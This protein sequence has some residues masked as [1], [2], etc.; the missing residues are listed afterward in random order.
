MDTHSIKVTVITVTY[1]AK[2]ALEKTMHSID[3]Q[4]YTNLEY[5][6]VDGGSLDGT[7]SLLNSYTGKLER[8]ISEPDMG[9]YDAMNKGVAM[10]TGDYCLFMN[11]GD[12]FAGPSVV[13][14]VV[15]K[16]GGADVIYGDILKDGNLKK[17]LSPRNCHK[18]YYC[19]QAVFTR[20]N[21]LKEYPF[22][23]SHRFS[24]D[25]KQ[26]KQLY[27][28]GKTFKQTNIVI[29]VFDTTGISNTQRS[30]GL[31]DNIRVICEVDSIQEKIRILPRIL[32]SYWFCRL[33]GK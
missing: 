30:K 14:Q 28:A 6:V 2:D 31:L 5:I 10:A 11:A 9:I 20:T 32:F 27:L 21:C 12:C 16:F 26:A 3:V 13:S 8:W 25:F 4:D 23:I 22:D 24:A 1:N 19:H 15:K 18:M 29:A 7:T 33:R 17:S